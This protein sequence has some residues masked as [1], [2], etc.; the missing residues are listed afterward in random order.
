MLETHLRTG[1]MTVIGRIL[2]SSNHALL[3]DVTDDCG[4]TRAIYKPSRGERPLWDFALG[5][6]T[7]R[8]VAAARVSSASGLDVVPVTVMRDD[9]PFG[10]GSVQEWIT[11]DADPVVGVVPE[12]EV[13]EGWLPVF[14]GEGPDGEPL[15]VVHVDSPQLRAVAVFDAMVNNTDRKGAH[16]L[17]HAGRVLGVDHGVCFHTEDKLRTVLWGWAGELIEARLLT[18]VETTEHAL[19]DAL[20]DSLRLLLDNA[21]V[22]A[23][24]ERCRRLLERARYPLPRTGWPAIPWPPL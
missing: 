23:L 2:D 4:T 3:V 8:E 12:G 6:L 22:E 19:G 1:E 10:A 18:A 24:H 14:R 21:E 11:P 15:V 5:S 16:L 20:G 13:P 7:A 17:P 9:A